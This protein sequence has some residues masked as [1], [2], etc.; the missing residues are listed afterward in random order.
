MPRGNYVAPAAGVES[1]IAN[2]WQDVLGIERVGAD[3]DFFE[4]GGESLAAVHV[5]AMVDEVLLAPVSFSDFVEAPTVVALAEVVHQARLTAPDR[6][7]LPEPPSPVGGDAPLT[8]AQERLWFL[9]QLGAAGA[10]YNMP[11]GFRLRGALDVGALRRALQDVVDRHE[12]LRTALVEEDGRPVQRVRQ[13]VPVELELADVRDHEDPQAEASRLVDVLVS[14]PIPLDA[15]PLLRALLVRVAEHEHVLELVFHHVVCDGASHVVVARELLALHGAHARGQAAELPAPRAQ[16]PEH[17]RRERA[18]LEGEA[19]RTAVEPWLER[20]AGCP[21]ALALPT[22]RPR[23]ELPSYRGAT[24][25]LRLERDLADRVRGFARSVRATPFATLLA[26]YYLLLHRRSGQDDIVIGATTSGRDAP[27]LEDGVGLFAST[28]ALRVGLDGS[29]SFAEL[30]GRVRDMVLWAVAHERAPFDQVVAQL[31]LARDLSRHPVFQVFVAHVPHVPLGADGLE[32][33]PYDARPTTSR[34]DLT[35]FMEEERGDALELAWEYSTDLFDAA[36]IERLAREYIELLEAALADPEQPVV[37]AKPPMATAESR[38]GG[39]EAAYPV[40]CMHERFEERAAL[41]PT[42]VALVYEGETLTYAQLNERA[43]RL[44]HHLRARGAGPESMVALFLEPSLEMIVAIL[45]VLKAGAAYVPIDPEY[46]AERTAFLLEDTAAPLLVT[47]SALLDRLPRHGATP[48]RLDADGEAIGAASVLN[49]DP[50]ARPENLAYVIYTSGSTGRPKGVQVEHRQVARLFTATDAWYGFGPADTWPLLHS[51]AF[52][53]SVWEIWGALAYGGR[54]VIS[55]LWTTR[56]AQALAGLIAEQGVTVM[57][58][59]PSLFVVVQDELLRVADRLALRHVVFGGEALQPA[60]LRPW[61]ERFGDGGPT[62]V[63]MYGITETTVHVTY[64]PIAPADCARDTSPIGVPIPDLSIHLLDP[65]GRPVPPGA[66]GELY[67]GGAGVTRGYLNRPELRAERFLDNPFRPGRL[68][69]SGDLARRRSDGELEF[70]GRI[71]DQVKIRGF[72]IE[73]GEVDAAIREL[74]GVADCAVVAD[75]AAPGDVRLAAYVV[76]DGDESELRASLV[77]HL[78]ARLPEYMVPTAIMQLDRLPL[79]RNGKTDRK[80]LPP[81]VWDGRDGGGDPVVAPLTATEQT[82]AAVWQEVLAVD[83]VG[84]EDNFFNLGGHSLLAARATTRL[85]E[86][87]GVELSVRALFQEPTLSALA[88]HVDSLRPKAGGAGG[89]EA[90]SGGDLAPP[91]REFP[92]S[93]Q[94]QQLVYFDALEPGSVTY[95]AAL[96]VHTTGELDEAAFRR[97]LEAVIE[98]H[99]ALRTV[100]VWDGERETGTQRVLDRWSVELD[101]VDLTGVPAEQRG[102]ELDHLL[103]ARARRPFSLASDV[104][105]RATVFW[106]GADERVLLFQTHHVAFDAWAVEVF[107][108]D[109]GELYAAAHERRDAQLPELPLRHGEFA[110]RQR[111][112]LSGEWLERELDFWRA[113]LAGAPTVLALPT[114]HPRAALQTDDGDTHTTLLGSDLAQAL[115]E[116]CREHQVTP[117][118][119]LLAAFT[120]LLYRRSGQDDI[121]LGGPMANR[122]Q[123]ELEHL[124]GFFANTVVV[125]SRLGGNPTFA[126]LL[127]RVR[128]SVL[129]SYEHQEVPLELVVDALRPPRVPGVNPLI[130]VNFR[131]RVGE[132][133]V[134]RLP[135]A[136]TSLVPVDAGIA[137]FDLALELH[138]LDDLVEGEWNW[139]TDLFERPTILAL[140]RDFEALLRQALAEPDASILSYALGGESGQPVAPVGEGR[141]GVRSA[142]IRQFRR[143]GGRSSA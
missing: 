16:Y 102:A 141:E 133:P 122:A 123:P 83:S 39:A 51:Y 77:A 72:R 112:R 125:R 105:L 67:V 66:A 100:L 70:R 132:P 37:A 137:R 6:R 101:D 120:T 113:S 92:L 19:L 30:V 86:R 52:D 136:T 128:D 12:A 103:A 14:R 129:G 138:V 55:P 96:A 143:D 2:I 82:V 80:A 93:F 124:V 106:L 41:A 91:R 94:Q 28:V 26:G 99:E 54:L 84:R 81:P 48:I 140:G 97:A 50:L 1:A 69:R 64:R 47:H 22:D 4:L 32:V 75:E 142:G 35:L 121:L 119:V 65:C 63:N 90:P 24:H 108:R 33:E 7:G 10:A 45:G 31:P 9:E 40:A 73:L 114:D 56:S 87:F 13:S 89:G 98:R 18:L 131:V 21:A 111:E 109:L 117:Y 3:D 115:R 17:A 116:R 11:L 36:T 88:A 8:Y 27:G 60:A 58:A 78:R 139:R 74:A 107:Y 130:Q 29:P 57:N 15:P 127:R 76:A 38:I 79:T 126:E 53:F 134:L 104:L 44:A 20:L 95:N 46:P 23:P 62:L 118:M 5:L 43:N 61:F 34:F 25:R 59:T 68:Y 42:A 49:P 135:R 85:R 71:D 110:D